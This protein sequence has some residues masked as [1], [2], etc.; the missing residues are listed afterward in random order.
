VIPFPTLTICQPTSSGKD[1]VAGIVT[2]PLIVTCPIDPT[3][4]SS[5]RVAAEIE[6]LNQFDARFMLSSSKK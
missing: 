5:K 3:D 2:V 4:I 1:G 6:R